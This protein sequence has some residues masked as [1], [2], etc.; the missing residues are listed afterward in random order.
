MF[1]KTKIKEKEAGDGP[2]KK[3][4]IKYFNDDKSW[5]RLLPHKRRN[6]LK[7]VEGDYPIRTAAVSRNFPAT[8]FYF[9]SFL[10]VKLF[11]AAKKFSS[12]NFRLL[13]LL[14]MIQWRI[15][16]YCENFPILI[17][18]RYRCCNRDLP[19]SLLFLS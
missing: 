3:S 2:F 8:E 14:L 11:F 19:I 1:E 10:K 15:P 4:S 9:T 13:H 7:A 16:F 6:Q 18:S 17:S 5:N 12:D